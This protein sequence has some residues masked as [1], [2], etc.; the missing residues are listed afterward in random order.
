MPTFLLR[1]KGLRTK[2]DEDRLERVLRDA[3]GVYG[4]VANRIDGCAEIDADDDMVTIDQLIELAGDAG[5]DAALG[6]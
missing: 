5:F 4:A 1:I 6:G 3:R 2:E